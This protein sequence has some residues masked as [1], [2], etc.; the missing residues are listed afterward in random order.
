MLFDRVARKARSRITGVLCLLIVTVAFSVHAE[1]EMRA[2]SDALIRLNTPEGWSVGIRHQIDRREFIS[3]SDILDLDLLHTVASLGYS[4]LPF[5]HVKVEAGRSK[6]EAIEDG[7][8]GESG[9]EWSASAT[10]NVIEHKLARA[11]SVGAK[12]A[13]SFAIQAGVTS[14]ESNFSDRDFSWEEMYFS[15]TVTYVVNRQAAARWHSHEPTGTAIRGGLMFSHVDG[16]DGGA[17]I[18]ENRDFAFRAGADARTVGGWVLSLDGTF[19]GGNDHTL[20]LG[21][22]YNF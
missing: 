13:V 5:L 17:S 14:S 21:L 9:F 4:V 1:G 19:F 2:P 16:D 18:E 15:P 20:S 11:T 7:R 10:A 3:G 22:N 12:R 8:E 6:A